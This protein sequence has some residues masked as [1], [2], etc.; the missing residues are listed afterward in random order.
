MIKL[1]INNQPVEV[2][3]GATVLE[4]ALKAGFE[5]PTMCE[6]G[7]VE[8]FASCMVCMVKDSKSGGLLPACSSLAQNNSV[9]ITE[10]AEIFEARKTAIELLMSEHVGDCQAPCQVACP[11]NMDIPSMNRLLAAGD[12]EAALDVVLRDIA[13]P[14]VLGRICPAPCEGVCRRKPMDG[15]VAICSLKRFSYDGS[16]PRIPSCAPSN[17][18]KISIVGAGPAGLS[19]AFYLRLRGYDVDVYDAQALPGGALRYSVMK[20]ALDR[21]VLDAE[22]EVIAQMGANFYCGETIDKQRFEKLRTD[23]NVVILATGNLLEQILDW[24]LNND[25]K[26][27]LID[28]K[29]YLTNLNAVF[30]IGN[31]NRA[32]KLAIRSAAQGKEVAF[33]VDQLLKGEPL[34]GEPKRFNSTIGRLQSEEFV[35]YL[36]AASDAPRHVIKED[37]VGLD[38]G[39][40]A[41]F[42]AATAMAEAKRCM[43]CDCNKLDDCVLRKHAD[44]FQIAKRRFA[45]SERVKVSRQITSQLVVFEP[46]K[47]I[48]C[49]ICV[50][51]T[52]KHQET[53]GFT[54]IGRGFDVVVGVPLNETLEAALSTT[55]EKVVE[56][57]PTGALGYSKQKK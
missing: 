41:G 29:T 11:A 42:D 17:G 50:R 30:A 22:I 52:A 10:D 25:G 38:A 9:L 31:S 8:H 36:Q 28:K 55:A 13:L 47:C 4:A 48:K 37:A 53:F 7:S 20:E 3:S 21:T 44:T 27:L 19:A 14:G 33:S 34:T 46:G 1:T 49:G 26:H 51:I 57:C 56:A 54:F 24:G 16:K 32:G 35:H 45:Y 6:N 40:A 15:A 2:E 43:D 23:Y 5:I 39:F 18:F 12:T